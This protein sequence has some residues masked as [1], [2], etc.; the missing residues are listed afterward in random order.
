M[1]DIQEKILS[2][3]DID[4]AGENIF[5][6][7][8]IDK[9]DLTQDELES[10]IAATRKRWTQSINGANEK[11][12]E[13]DRARLEKA[14]KYEAILRDQ[15]LFKAV[16]DFYNK[17]A[18][19]KTQSAAGG[20]AGGAVEFARDYFNLIATSKKI[21][22][23]DVE[24]F[25]DYYQSVRKNK[26]AILEMLEKEFKVIAL[27][28][29]EKYAKEDEDKDV[30]GKT[31]DESSPLIVNLFQEATIIKLRKC[32]EFYEK[33]LQSNDVCQKY[34]SL[35]ESLYDFLELKSI[36]TIQQFSEYVSSRQKE[37][38]AVRQERGTDFVP[39][40]DLFNTLQTIATYRDVVDNFSETKLLIKYPTLTPYMYSISEMKPGTL[41]GIISIADREYE[42][43]DDTDFILN[44]YNPVHDNFGIINS[45]IA[46]IIKKAEKKANQNK[47][48]K[49]IDEK[50][51]RK[52][53][54]EIP[55]WAEIIHWLA[56]WPI[57][58]V[59]IIFE[60]FKVIFTNLPKLTIPTFV[61]AFI[62]E[63]WML[64][65]S[66]NIENLLYLRKIFIKA[67]WIQYIEGFTGESPGNA[68]EAILLTLIVII[69]L[70][71]I[72]VLPPLLISMFVSEASKELNEHYDWIGYE[73]TFKEVLK[74]LKTKTVEQFKTNEKFFAKK[75]I[76]AIIINLICTAIVIALIILTPIGFRAFSE[77]T[78]YFQ[79]NTETEVV[80]AATD[81]EMYMTTVE[82]E[83]VEET[84][85]E[86]E[87]EVEEPVWMVIT[88]PEANI[89]SGAGKDNGI[90]TMAHEGD[91]LAATGNEEVS[92][93]GD[94]WYEIYLDEDRQQTGWASQVVIKVKEDE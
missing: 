47:V 25:F 59:Y 5:K 48:L 87:E 79:K 12:A 78:G 82:A 55:I 27:G 74:T 68:F 84:E 4:I 19:K 92:A 22:K 45:G 89:R 35:K 2:K 90:V 41:K 40:V 52:K 23:D 94:T 32:V 60:I 88:V 31:K 77:K 62:A 13:R 70:L 38:F 11:I 42:F 15:K 37:V 26:K 18:E 91:T 71:A 76:P 51:G 28:N 56:Y 80:E 93:D 73:R 58:L 9:A 7:Y 44:Y 39:L 3:Y 14:D 54:R 72:Y 65:K 36:D 21:K 67:E 57:F 50:I 64:P 1:A 46:G 66:A 6:L 81:D 83:P 17:G 85:E 24:F 69:I 30:N 29:E 75:K 34:P 49:A 20:N 16:Y 61:I 8:K 43:R 53:K 63:N 33:A 86:P 10:L